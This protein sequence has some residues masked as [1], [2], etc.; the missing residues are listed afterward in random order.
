[1]GRSGSARL[2]GFHFCYYITTL[3]PKTIEYTSWDP[4]RITLPTIL[5]CRLKLFECRAIVFN[6]MRSLHMIYRYQSYISVA[7]NT[8][9]YYLVLL[10]QKQI[11]HFNS[12]VAWLYRYLHNPKAHTHA[13]T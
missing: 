8:V 6:V 12:R 2:P 5:V 1:M 7:F 9:L 10:C 4:A 3:L 11:Y 13:H